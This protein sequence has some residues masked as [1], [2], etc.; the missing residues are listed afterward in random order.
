MISELRATLENDL[1]ACK[2][3]VHSAWPAAPAA[4]C[5]I[6]VPSTR[7]NYVTAGKTFGEYVLNIDV[8]VLVSRDRAAGLRSLDSLV[9]AVLANTVDW[10]FKGTETPSLVNVG[11]QNVLG[12]IVQ[13]GKA[14]RLD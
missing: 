5:L 4:P 14:F 11:S 2:V 6:V 13:L 7:E 9:E 10:A 1:R 8:L 3:Q 12:S